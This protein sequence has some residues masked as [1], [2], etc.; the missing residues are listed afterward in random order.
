MIDGA[1]PVLWL[2]GP[3]GVGKTTVAW[4]LYAQLTR[5]G[6]AVGY[7]DI[8]QLGMCY[9]ESA[10]DPGRHRLKARNLGSM[11]EGFRAHG[12][13]CV[14]VSGVV[15]ADHGVY[16]DDLG[17]ADLTVCLLGAGHEELRQRFVGRDGRYETVREVLAEADQL[18]AGPIADLR[19]DTTGRTVADVVRLVRERTGWSVLDGDRAPV[20]QPAPDPVTAD[21][22]ILWICGPTGIGKS[23]VGFEVY[24]K[25]MRTEAIAA[26]IDLGQIGFAEPTPDAAAAHRLRAHNL[27]AIWHNYHRVG[28]RLLVITG[29]IRDEI[30]RKAYLDALPAATFTV[31]RL[32][33]GAATL[34]E[35]ILRRRDGGSW[36]EPGDP[37]KGQPT[38]YLRR[39]ADRA[40]ADA[41]AL[42]RIELGD[43]RIDTDGLPTTEVADRVI[44]GSGWPA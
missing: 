22:H 17:H 26:Y 33:A 15:D 2:T 30:A 7:V 28:A 41:D 3:P 43:V 21:G 4:E 13:D 20:R 32:R 40:V 23:T 39:V 18:D 42:E 25:T 27:A 11:I 5:A 9:P 44:A 31:C 1:T 16:T 8:D 37:L 29:P 34:T 6:T 14:I 10:E 19:V 36:A 35:R 12:T 24:L 38:S